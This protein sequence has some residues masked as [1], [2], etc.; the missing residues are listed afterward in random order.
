MLKEFTK[1][2]L[3]W[4]V[5]V[6]RDFAF[7]PKQVKVISKD[8]GM[9]TYVNDSGGEWMWYSN[10]FFDTQ[11]ECQAECD[12][13]TQEAAGVITQRMIDQRNEYNHFRDAV[14]GIWRIA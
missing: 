12:L 5:D 1:D 13:L 11:E 9:I 4:K 6:N 14:G 2:G 8:R 10:Q 7:V 3:A